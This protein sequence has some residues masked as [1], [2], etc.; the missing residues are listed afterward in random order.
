MARVVPFLG[1]KVT[2]ASGQV[3]LASA[4]WR[5]GAGFPSRLGR[6][7]LKKPPP[8][9]IGWQEMGPSL[10][11]TMTPQVT[12]AVLSPPGKWYGGLQSTRFVPG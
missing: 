10:A 11:L 12:R 3:N 5:I 7:K 4:Q 6:A 8:A 2:N 9:S 1:V